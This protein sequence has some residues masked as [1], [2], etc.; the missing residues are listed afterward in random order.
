MN[1]NKVYISAI[2]TRWQ[3]VNISFA[4]YF[5]F[6]SLFSFSYQG[7][8]IHLMV[9]DKLKT[10]TSSDTLKYQ[11][12]LSHL[13]I[14]DSLLGLWRY[15]LAHTFPNRINRSSWKQHARRPPEIA[16]SKQPDRT[17]GPVSEN[18]TVRV[19]VA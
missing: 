16:V 4:S 1:V 15:M 14:S 8:L 13:F 18:S 9:L 12:K 2:P 5:G 3:F 7:P 11:F 6:L 10:K 19:V 17:C